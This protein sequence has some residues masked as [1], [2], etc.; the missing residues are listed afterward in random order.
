MAVKNSLFK[1]S[2]GEIQ[3]L[4]ERL[5][6]IIGIPLSYKK[7]C[8]SLELPSKTGGAKINQINDLSSICKI[9]I[10]KSPTR[11]EVKEVYDE[12]I[13]LL[14]LSSN[15]NEKRLKLFEACFYREFLSNGC[16]PICLSNMQLLVFFK[17]VNE[18]FPLAY[19]DVI[20]RAISKE[21]NQDFNY[22]P[23]AVKKIYV[24]LRSWAQ[25]MVETMTKQSAIAVQYSFRL[26]K[27]VYIDKKP[28]VIYKDILISNDEDY[29]K[30]M[31]IFFSNVQ[32]YL[33]STWSGEYVDDKL[34]K[35][36]QNGINKDVK[37]VFATGGWKS[38]KRIFAYYPSSKEIIK[39]QLLKI[40]WELDVTLINKESQN[41]IIVKRHSGVDFI[42]EGE[43]IK[44]GLSV[45]QKDE[46]VA[47]V[48]ELNPVNDFRKIYYERGK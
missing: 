25:R 12:V 30:C 19:D 23:P 28:R 34:W 40:C 31:S 15:E 20:M 4:K 14:K 37:E 33:G 3:Q 9:E 16:Q 29:K 46:L 18:N 45:R 2:E 27:T 22:M 38:M 7:L 6:G 44:D 48:I 1:K 10:S 35:Q 36:F 24:F 32:K 5:G 43:T 39:S 41:R 17:Q 42:K 21:L 26:Y 11:Y 13:S 8:G 47:N